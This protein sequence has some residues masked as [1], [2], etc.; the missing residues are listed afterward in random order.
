MSSTRTDYVELERSLHCG[1]D[2]RGIGRDDNEG[3]AV[4]EKGYSTVTDFARFRGRSTF[5]P[6]A[7]AM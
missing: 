1:R 3:L 7:S 6:L 4:I 2:D 5:K